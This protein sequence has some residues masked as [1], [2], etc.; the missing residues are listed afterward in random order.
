M[1]KTLVA[2]VLALS[3][4]G[5]F[6][7]DYGNPPKQ[8]GPDSGNGSDGGHVTLHDPDDSC[9]E[10]PPGLLLTTTTRGIEIDTTGMSN[11][12]RSSCGGAST[13]GNDAFIGVLAQ[14]GVYWHFHLKNDPT[15]VDTVDRQPALYML[16]VACDERACTFASDVCAGNGDE[17]FGFV[18]PV[19][20]TWYLG[21]DDRMPGG[22]HYVLDAIR[23]TCGDGMTDHGEA[24]DD[25]NRDDGDGCTHDCLREISADSPSEQEANDN[26][27]EANYLVIPASGEFV[28][29]GAIG[30]AGTCRY[31]DTFAID[32]PAGAHVEVDVLDNTGSV[33]SDSALTSQYQ[34]ALRNG[35]FA[36]VMAGQNDTT[37]GCAWIRSQALTS[38]G[39]YYVAVTLPAEIASPVAYHLRIRLVAG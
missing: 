5:C 38:G 10:D 34:L 19:D 24:C 13:E 35:S 26:P 16:P 3:L 39:R 2:L 8:D 27:T 17:H 14:A 23:P 20:G 32:V 18:S 9:G 22:G 33:C 15:H 29:N 25:G 11:A 31:A 37:T 21:I 28:V 12:I 30:G 7:F 4:P 1:K 6:V 36:D